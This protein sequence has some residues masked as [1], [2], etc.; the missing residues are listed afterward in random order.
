MSIFFTLIISLISLIFLSIEGDFSEMC[1]FSGISG[2]SEVFRKDI[3][4]DVK[5]NITLYDKDQKLAECT[6]STLHNFCRNHDIEAMDYLRID[7]A[8][9]ELAIIESIDF[10]QIYIVI[11][12]VA[13]CNDNDHIHHILAHKGYELI[14]TSQA[15]ICRYIKYLRDFGHNWSISKELFDYIRSI[16]A[17]GKTILELG[18]GWASSE[19]SKYYTVYSIEHNKYWLNKF[20]THYIYAPIKDRWYDT[21]ILK[22]KLPKTY[23]LILVDGPPGPTIGR[24]G[25]YTNLHLFNTDVPI[26][27]DDVNRQAEYDLMVKVANTLNRSFI[28]F[29]DSARKQFGVLL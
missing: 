12:D 5:F 7:S 10:D 3:N 6:C 15:N 18:S 9:K 8:G 26:I 24:G 2:H 28:I 17:K 14:S 20:N 16:L 11:V 23:D 22:N 29:D 21:E 4:T 25:F 13:N 1:R 19:L 27:F